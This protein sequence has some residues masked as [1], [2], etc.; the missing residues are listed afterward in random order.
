[1]VAV[2]VLIL[3]AVGIFYYPTVFP[4]SAQTPFAWFEN[5]VYV[6]LLILAEYLCVQRLRNAVITAV[7]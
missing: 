5:D 7:E 4:P 3:I 2:T 1:V 6:G